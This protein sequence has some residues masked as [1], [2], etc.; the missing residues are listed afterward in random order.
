MS[1]NKTITYKEFKP[2]NLTFT[3]FEEND[4]SNGQLVSFP[5]YVH[6]GKEVRVE[7]QTPWIDLDMYGIPTLN[8]K[9][10]NY[11]KTD[12]D[13]AHLRL[14]LDLSK[15]EIAEFAN[16]LKAIDKTNNDPETSKKL[17]GKN[18][19]KYTYQT[20][21]RE[22][23]VQ[24][25]DD[26][27]DED[28]APKKPSKT[29]TITK[30]PYMKGK[31]DVEYGTD[32]IK[33]KVFNSVIEDPNEGEKR[34]RTP[35]EVTTVDDICSVVKYKSRIRCVLKPF[36]GWAHPVSKKD[37]EFG[38]GWKVVRIE[39][40]NVQFSQSSTND[41]NEFIDSDT[42][43][44]L[45]KVSSQ[46]KKVEAVSK[47]DDTDESDSSD[48][49]EAVLAPSQPKIVE[50]DSSDDESEDEAPPPPKT[51]KKSVKSKK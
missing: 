9:T 45:P 47:N 46:P 35:I 25:N 7:I 10:K 51:T 50:V 37:P 23:L 28:D 14:P 49:E 44:E 33:T 39:V 36:K 32:N 40:D 42:E 38:I 11:Y 21:F 5:R 16:K 17:L 26:D 20:I 18:S 43:D 31:L 34:K 4:R 13:R 8:E 15:P 19:K 6:E 29:S 48:S 12:K 30:L 3:K 41:S 2:E 27:D 24:Q 1:E 22:A